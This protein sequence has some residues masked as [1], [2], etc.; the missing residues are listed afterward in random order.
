MQGSQ[1]EFSANEVRVSG[2]DALVITWNRKDLLT[3]C[4][5]AILAQTHP[6]DRLLI[7][8]NGSTDGTRDHLEECGYLNHPKVEYFR[9][10]ANGGPAFGFNFGF[11]QALRGAHNWLWVMDDDVIP[12]SDA[13]ERLLTA[14]DENFKESRSIGFLVSVALAPNG[15]VMNVP[16]PDLRLSST[17]YADWNH[18]LEK[19]LAKIRKATF[20]SILFPMTTLEDFGLPRKDFFIWGEDIDYTMAVTEHRPG[21]QVGASKVVH[22]RASSK[23]PSIRYESDPKRTKLL[24]YYYR[25]QFYLKRRYEKFPY[26][27]GQFVT[28]AEAIFLSVVKRPFNFSRVRAVVSGVFAGL[29][30]DPAPF[31]ALPQPARNAGHDRRAA[32]PD[33]NRSDRAPTA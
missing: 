24:F 1:F 26:V 32:P 22:C 29:F 7:V 19:G 3:E 2:V 28:S 14:F 8:D 13:L 12:R 31:T 27:L 15:G 30:F 11:Q 10:E 4:V 21:Y 25:N 17:G 9:F 20:V 6:I 18:L 33:L 23:P 5:G 16:Q